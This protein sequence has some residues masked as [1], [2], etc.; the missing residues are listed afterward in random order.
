MQD[1][2]DTALGMMAARIS[3]RMNE[4]IKEELDEAIRQPTLTDRKEQLIG[5][6]KQFRKYVC[7]R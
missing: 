6:K 1:V 2:Y 3:G 7:T 5:R 4:R